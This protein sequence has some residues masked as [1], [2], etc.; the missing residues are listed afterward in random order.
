[1]TIDKYDLEDL[2][3][4]ALRKQPTLAVSVSASDAGYVLVNGMLDLGRLIDHLWERLPLKAE[5][6]ER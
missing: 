3:L 6:P 4:E 2:V 5:H 1:M